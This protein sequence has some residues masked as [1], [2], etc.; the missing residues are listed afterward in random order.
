[1]SLILQSSVEQNIYFKTFTA[2]YK[3]DTI[4]ITNFSNF[5]K[6]FNQDLFEELS[7][8]KGIS[9]IIDSVCNLY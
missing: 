3:T 6:N 1:M 4:I 2:D 8:E 9:D 7:Q 5:E